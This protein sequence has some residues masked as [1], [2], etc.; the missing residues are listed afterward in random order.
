MKAKTEE[1]A[2]ARPTPRPLDAAWT[3]TFAMSVDD[4][5]KLVEQKRQFYERVMQKGVH[6]DNIEGKD[7]PAL[8]KAGAE[9]LLSAMGLHP[10]VVDAEEPIVDVTGADHGGEPFIMYRRACMVW[11]QTG[12]GENDRMLIAQAGG[13]CSSFEVKYRYRMAQRVCPICGA[14][15]IM[16]SRDD[17]TFYC[18]RRKGGCGATFPVGDQRITSQ[19]KG[20]IKN[21]DVADLANTILKMADKRAVVAATLLATGCSDIFTQ[22]VED[23]GEPSDEN[24]NGHRRKP[25]QKADTSKGEAANEL[26]RLNDALPEDK[27]WSPAMLKGKLTM[28]P[29]KA[30]AEMKAL[31][32]KYHKPTCEC[33]GAPAAAEAA[34]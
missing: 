28:P 27:R 22:D 24:G 31:H 5:V 19:V 17:D 20:R 15:A 2:L 1:K 18:W 14:A 26:V 10:Q 33:F 7:K 25:E 6:Y 4:A 9:L 32:E 21:P 8:L 3:P 29:E 34:S 16:E 30:L 12:P 23:Q 11:R 13:S